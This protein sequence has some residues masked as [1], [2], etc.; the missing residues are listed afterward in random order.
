MVKLPSLLSFF[1]NC[2]RAVPLSLAA[3]YRISIDFFSYR[4]L[5]VSVPYVSFFTLCIQ[6]KIPRLS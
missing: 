3:T 6:I 5:D 4:Y 1:F 2:L